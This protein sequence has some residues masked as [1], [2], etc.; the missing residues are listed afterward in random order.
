MADAVDQVL[1]NLPALIPFAYLDVMVQESVELKTVGSE[2]ILE[3]IKYKR[4]FGK[5]RAS[6]DEEDLID[7]HD[8]FKNFDNEGDT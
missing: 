1:L 4:K 6:C 5:E 7:S 8:V 2:R 3:A